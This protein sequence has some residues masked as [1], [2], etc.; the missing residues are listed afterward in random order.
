MSE[1]N[2]HRDEKNA[3]YCEAC[4]GYI[5]TINKDDGV[6][7]FMIGC[8]VLGEPDDPANTCKG[9]MKSMFYPKEP[10]PEKDGFG[11]EIPTEPTHEWY[12]PTSGELNQMGLTMES[13]RFAAFVEHVNKGG[14]DIRKVA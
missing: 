5:V 8:R 1:Y 2:E 7:P 10:W 12:K 3:Y 11:N 9:M 4:K 6:T 14:L 13:H